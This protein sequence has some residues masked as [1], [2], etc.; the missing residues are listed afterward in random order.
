MLSRDYYPVL[1][2]LKGKKVLLRVDFNVKIKNNNVVSDF[3][4]GDFRIV[5]R[6]ISDCM[7]IVDE[8]VADDGPEAEQPTQAEGLP[9]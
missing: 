3:I 6:Y 4:K 7:K 8:S 9:L 2:E 1:E 5:Y